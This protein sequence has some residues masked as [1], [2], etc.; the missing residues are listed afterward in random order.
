MR[1]AITIFLIFMT[2]GSFAQNYDE[3][4]NLKTGDYEDQRPSLAG[5]WA[6]SK[7]T[8]GEEELTPTAKW[9]ELLADGTQTSGNGWVQNFK[10][11][12]RF[13]SA[14][15]SFLSLDDQGQPDEYGAFKVSIDQKNMTCQRNEDGMP[16]QVA[17]YRIEEK[18]LAPW[19]KITGRWTL[20][21]AETLNTETNVSEKVDVESFSYYIGWDRRYRRFDNAGKRIESGI[22][23][24]E[25]HS[26]WLWFIPYGEQEK[27]GQDLSIEGNKMTLTRKDGH[28]VY[29]QY[30]S[31]D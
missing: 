26:P 18:P 30:F 13:D 23:H 21:G 31:R 9:F 10:G 11:Q 3:I 24:I 4:A 28:M 14:A 1:Q 12:W 15:S 5:L 20:T 7:V 6:V 8:V 16:V 19:D 17:L 22:W 27:R 2:L 29:K 25:P